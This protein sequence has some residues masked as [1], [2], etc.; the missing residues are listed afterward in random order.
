MKQLVPEPQPPPRGSAALPP[1]PPAPCWAVSADDES[2]QADTAPSTRIP[3]TDK[4]LR[5]ALRISIRLL[6]ETPMRLGD[7]AP[8]PRRCA[9][10]PHGSRRR[11]PAG[12]HP[13]VTIRAWRA[14][15]TRLRDSFVTVGRCQSAGCLP[16]LQAERMPLRCAG[17]CSAFT[18]VLLVPR[19]QPNQS[20][21]ARTLSP[22]ETTHITMLR[23]ALLLDLETRSRL[24]FES[25]STSILRR[26]G[27]P[28][29]HLTAPDRMLP[30]R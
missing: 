23:F 22:G 30:A 29:A 26:R 19:F 1:V 24:R 2:E 13:Q 21:V 8:R 6:L 25:T 16:A 18:L 3:Q 27:R 4:I 20:A 7:R 28:C 11:T 12:A 9:I 17:A 5:K 14:A 10:R 15:Q